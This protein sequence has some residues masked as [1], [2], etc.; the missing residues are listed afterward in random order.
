MSDLL[1][2]PTKWMKFW[3]NSLIRRWHVMPMND[4]FE[5]TTTNCE[6][7]PVVEVYEEQP[8]GWI[9]FSIVHNAYD[10]RP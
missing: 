5:H 9:A 2:R 1:D 8:S 6:C 4:L 3:E 10:G 7:N